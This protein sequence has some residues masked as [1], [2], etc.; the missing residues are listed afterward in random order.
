MF[1]K[2]TCIEKETCCQTRNGLWSCCPIENGICCDD[3]LHCCSHGDI[4][5]NNGKCSSSNHIISV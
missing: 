2:V 4:C 1:F 5:L 3:G